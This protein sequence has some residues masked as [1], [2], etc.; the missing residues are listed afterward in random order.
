MSQ[1]PSRCFPHPKVVE[2]GSQ[3]SRSGIGIL[4][5]GSGGHSSIGVTCRERVREAEGDLG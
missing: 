1:G 4:T 5:G 2:V 3:K